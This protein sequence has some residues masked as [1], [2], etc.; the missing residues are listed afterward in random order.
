[1]AKKK[2]NES[3]A[4]LR[5]RTSGEEIMNISA[6]PM[7]LDVNAKDE[8]VNKDGIIEQRLKNHR[9]NNMVFSMRMDQ[10][11]LNHIKQ[12]ARQESARLKIDVPYQMLIAEAVEEKYPEEK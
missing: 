4:E 7:T 11:L 10:D 12:V 3:I 8:D 5:T 9:A 6:P 2:K 1:M